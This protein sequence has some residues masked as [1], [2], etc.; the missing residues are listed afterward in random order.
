M[1]VCLVVLD[2]V[3]GLVVHVP[4]PGLPLFVEPQLH[5]LQHLGRVPGGG[6]G[7]GGQGGG[8]GGGG[9]GQGGGGEGWWW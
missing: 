5:L 1:L 3:D 2:D 9:V 6:G 7:G 4:L 8:G